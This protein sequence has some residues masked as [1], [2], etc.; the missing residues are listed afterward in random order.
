[1][2]GTGGPAD[3]A[4]DFGIILSMQP[5]LKS[6]QTTIGLRLKDY[7]FPTAVESIPSAQSCAMAPELDSVRINS[8]CKSRIGLTFF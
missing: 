3:R 8:R 1:V 2:I 7:A 4:P 5:A 6:L